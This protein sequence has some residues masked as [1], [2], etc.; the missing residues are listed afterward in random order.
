LAAATN[1]P[2]VQFRLE[3]LN[4]AG[5]VIQ[6]VNGVNKAPHNFSND[7]A[8]R[9][10]FSFEATA[11]A[12][13]T[14]ARVVLAWTTAISTT[15]GM[16]YIK[17]EAGNL[18]STSYT[19]ETTGNAVAA[20][21]QQEAT[22]RATVD[23]QLLAQ[24]TVKTDLNGYVS[25]FGLASTLNTAT[26][27][28]TFAVRADAFYIA[29]PTGPGVPPSMPFIVRTTPVTIGGEVVPI[30]V[31]MSQAFIQ[32]GTITNAKIANAT[33]ENAKI[34]NLSAAKI[35]TGFLSADRI[36]AGSIT[37]DKLT[38]GSGKNII[39][40]SSWAER[41]GA[42]ANWWS[43]G[44]NLPTPPANVGINDPNWTPFGANV[45]LMWMNGEYGALNTYFQD[46][47]GGT[48]PVVEG[49]R[50]EFQGKT[51]SHRCLCRVEIAFYNSAG[52]YIGGANSGGGGI[53][54]NV[55]GDNDEERPG[56]LSLGSFKITGGFV[57]APV[58]ATRAALIF[59]KFNT[60]PGLGHT[61]SYM[62]FTHPMIAEATST[63][64]QLSPYEP[65]GL[66]TLIT[67]AGIST[68]SIAAISANLGSILTVTMDVHNDGS[69]GWGYIRTPGKWLNN[70]AYGWILARHGNGS[71]F[72]D[73]TAGPVHFHMYYDAANG[74]T[75]NYMGWPGFFV[76]NGGM[77]IT[78]LNVI[79][80]LNLA[81]N[82]V[83]VPTYTE[84]GG[85]GQINLNPGVPW[86][87]GLMAVALNHGTSPVLIQVTLQCELAAQ[88]D[89]NSIDFRIR[90]YRNGGLIVDRQLAGETVKGTLMLNYWLGGIGSGVT[91]QINIY[92]AN[93]IAQSAQLINRYSTM[94][95]LGIKR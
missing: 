38:I 37:A 95:A 6:T 70:G 59:R 26:P 52:T 79:D 30:G 85:F 48:C 86:E 51:G 74:A 60:K 66:I 68:P 12:L 87:G 35:D 22:A 11:P 20:S 90:L 21:V 18:P 46:Y 29:N 92:A 78:Q 10:E 49:K 65:T 36:A 4:S 73:F 19:D 34:I 23:G 57:I 88:I 31:Y 62:F 45:V 7:P 64:T 17:V 24:W 89:L 93:Q 2:R 67:P 14:D 16:R 8:Q 75:D 84:T 91:Y 69:G 27:S 9:Q 13:A 61:S 72:M 55:T 71:T 63:Q 83:T 58:G 25:G 54:S 41:T 15:V 77:T 28:S 3:F 53:A 39:I 82:A 33:I 44:G 94:F 32:N 76:H 1:V 50:Y 56:G 43:T 81:G 80:T 5:A 47:W 40:N 42:I